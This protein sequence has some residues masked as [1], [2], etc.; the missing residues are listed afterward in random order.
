MA[1]KISGTTVIDNSC[2]V[3][4]ANTFTA[5]TFVGDGSGLTGIASP[6]EILT[7]T[8]TN[9]ANIANNVSLTPTICGSEY[10]S[11]YDKTH[12]CT[13]FQVSECPDFS[14]CNVFTCELAGSNTSISIPSDCLNYSTE[15]FF[16][17]RYEDEDGTCSA[18]SDATCF[19][20]CV[21][22]LATAALGDSVL[23]GFYMGTICAA[24]TCYYLIMSPNSGGCIRCVWKTTETNSG[25]GFERFDGYGNTYDHLANASHPAGNWTATRTIN[26]FSDWYLPARFEMCTLY[27]NRA[28]AP[29]GEAFNNLR[30]W[31]ST[32]H[33]NTFGFTILTDRG[34][35]DYADKIQC[36]TL[37]AIR[38]EPFF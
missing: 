38:R 20:T 15:H 2:N 9:P 18:F 25:V 12:T 14:T 21:N 17:I 28:C 11:L 13:C 35:F 3:T 27:Q 37:R 19:T 10:I 26:G 24:G 32:E 5:T 34:G 30:Y 6:T 8:N 1:I 7:P 22:P 23:G 16:R 36:C 31:T 33:N 29:G 4:N